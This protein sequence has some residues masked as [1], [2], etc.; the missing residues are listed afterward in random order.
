MDSG[1]ERSFATYNPGSGVLPDS[2][3]I[4]GGGTV[5]AGAGGGWVVNGTSTL[6]IVG[7]YQDLT[8]ISG[9]G[10]MAFV[11]GSLDNPGGFTNMN[12]SAAGFAITGQVT[13]DNGSITLDGS[14]T[15]LNVK[16][17]N[18]GLLSFSAPATL[19]AS[20]IV[21]GGAGVNSPWWNTS[22]L[23]SN[24]TIT[25]A[26][27]ELRPEGIAAGS[28]G[29]MVACA[30]IVLAN[31]PAVL[32]NGHPTNSQLTFAVTGTGGVAGTDFSQLEI[33][34]SYT[35]ANMITS[36]DAGSNPFSQT[37][38][39]VNIKPGMTPKDISSA[40]TGLGVV[41]VDPFA[42][43]S[44]QVLKSDA[45]WNGTSPAQNFTGSSFANVKVNGGFATVNYTNGYVT[46]TNIF[47]NPKLAGDINNDGLVDVA[48]Y[49]IWAANV[50]MTGATWL[51]GD[52]NGDGLVDV[53][54]YDIWAANVGAT[55]ATPEPISMIILAIG[56]GLVAL[57][58]R[59]G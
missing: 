13:I 34:T 42:G 7:D 17:L 26:G 35:A 4:S 37:N 15:G 40:A 45:F 19:T 16:M 39:V 1:G 12:V 28:A 52:L 38:L 23:F 44:L 57:K 51:Q 6:S 20:H 30:N 14:I 46:L 3:T 47:S 2:T 55:S 49:D 25:L 18:H 10:N 59:N 31:N 56:G 24:N 9:T 43:E 8:G 53:A 5:L 21:G 29:H 41:G 22:S 27:S 32:T 36:G 11:T 48:D 33:A 50:G 54:D 58:R